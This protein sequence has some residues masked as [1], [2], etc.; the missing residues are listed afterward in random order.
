MAGSAG[1]LFNG[2][3]SDWSPSQTLVFG[4]TSASPNPTLLAAPTSTV[5]EFP[6]WIILPFFASVLLI[7][8][9]IKYRRT[10]HE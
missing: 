10:S 1:Y 7:P 4:E 6:I 9:Y 3:S 2:Q 5:P 8:V